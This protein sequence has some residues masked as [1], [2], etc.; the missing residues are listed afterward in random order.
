MA[1]LSLQRGPDEPTWS[2]TTPTSRACQLRQSAPPAT[3]DLAPRREQV[4]AAAHSANSSISSRST[5]LRR[6]SASRDVRPVRTHQA[7]IA[8][9]KESPAPTVSTTSRGRAGQVIRRCAVAAIAPSGPR[10]STTSVGPASSSLPT[11]ASCAIPGY[12]NAKVC[13]AQANDVCNGAEALERRSCR[14][15]R[16]GQ[17]RPDVGVDRDESPSRLPFQQS[18]SSASARADEECERR[19]VKNCDVVGELRQVADFDVER[20]S[21][22]HVNVEVWLDRVV[23]ERHRRRQRALDDE[24]RVDATGLQVVAE[25]CAQFPG[26]HTRDQLCRDPQPRQTNGGIRGTSSRD[27]DEAPLAIGEQVDEDFAEDGSGTG[28][29]VGGLQLAL[30]QSG[31][32]RHVESRTTSDGTSRTWRLGCCSELCRRLMS[33]RAASKPSASPGWRMV[34]SGGLPSSARESS[35]PITATRSGTATPVE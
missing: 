17:T 12:R 4:I 32:R 33:S 1:A 22:L 20:S 21:R 25:Q 26:A 29:E 24:C 28:G 6:S 8:A 19:R 2:G 11:A 9:L 3:G 34:V 31:R 16:P 10:V 14:R 18:S 30:L 23:D 15:L 35:K 7:S 13:V 5:S 27:W